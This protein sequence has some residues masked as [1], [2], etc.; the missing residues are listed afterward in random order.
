M[1]CF[2]PASVQIK[3]LPKCVQGAVGEA[4]FEVGSISIDWGPHDECGLVLL[5]Q[6]ESRKT[7]F[8]ICLE[9]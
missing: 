1:I 7:P 8:F 9:G 6:S 5:T 3:S 4:V 2:L